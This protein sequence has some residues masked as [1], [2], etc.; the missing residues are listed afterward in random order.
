VTRLNEAANAA[1]KAPE[2][3]ELM[4][5]IGAEPL[6]GKPEEFATTISADIKKWT[7][8]FK[9]AKIELQ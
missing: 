6:G 4:E 2:V 3:R 7:E 5:R 1:L 9:S 8:V